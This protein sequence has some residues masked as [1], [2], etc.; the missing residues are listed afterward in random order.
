MDKTCLN[1]ANKLAEEINEI[2]IFISY[3]SKVWTGKLTIKDKIMRFISDSYGAYETK[4]LKLNTELKNRLL[5]VL[6]EYR[7]ELEK[8]FERM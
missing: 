7:E 3:A 1:R 5:H 2:D 6:D 8:E 4:E